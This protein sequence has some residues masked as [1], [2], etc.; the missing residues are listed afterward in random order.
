MTVG[1]ASELL[2]RINCV[3]YLEKDCKWC[4]HCNR[5]FCLEHAKI[6]AKELRKNRMLPMSY[7]PELWAKRQK[8]L[9]N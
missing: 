8:R 3:Q 4:T 1:C 2:D 5:I 9:S 7:S 6:H